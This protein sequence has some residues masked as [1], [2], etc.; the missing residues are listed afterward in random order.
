MTLPD[1]TTV[2]SRDEVDRLIT[3]GEATPLLAGHR[4]VPVHWNGCWWHLRTEDPP[5][6]G[7]QRAPEGLA[8][9]LEDRLQRLTRAAAA[10][11]EAKADRGAEL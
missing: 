11:R 3:A 5:E 7:Y 8:T 2:L 1:H 10:E 6:A 9:L 4:P